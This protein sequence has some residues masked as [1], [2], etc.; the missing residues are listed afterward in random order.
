MPWATL[1][2]AW[3]SFRRWRHDITIKITIRPP[4][5][6]VATSSICSWERSFVQRVTGFLARFLPIFFFFLTFEGVAVPVTDDAAVAEVS[7]SVGCALCANAELAS[8]I[9]AL[10]AAVWVSRFT[11]VISLKPKV[12]PPQALCRLGLGDLEKKNI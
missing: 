10:K 11:S 1:C 5:T 9:A 3:R 4:T 12:T 7:T 2:I 6:V 8:P